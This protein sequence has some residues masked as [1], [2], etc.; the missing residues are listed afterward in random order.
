MQ[1][2]C[3]AGDGRYVAAAAMLHAVLVTVKHG[4][5][6]VVVNDAAASLVLWA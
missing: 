1:D 4:A 5:W 3:T 2:T 6:V